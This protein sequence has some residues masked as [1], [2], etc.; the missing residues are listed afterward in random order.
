MDHSAH[1]N[2]LT[3]EQRR[4]GLIAIVVS[5]AIAGVILGLFNPLISL[6]L[7][8][9]DVSTT[10]N[11]V[12]AAMP[13]IAAIIV[14]PFLPRLTMALGLLQTI[15][16]GAALIMIVIPLF[17]VFTD[18]WV[19][20]GLRFVMGVGG[21]MHW[22]TTEIWI[23]AAVKDAYR[24]RVLGANT[25][26][27]SAGMACGPLALGIIGT[28]GTLPFFISTGIVVLGALPLLF[29]IGTAPPLHEPQKGA[30]LDACRRAP[31]PMVASLIEGFLFVAIMVLLPLY[32]LRSGFA[33]SAA[34]TMLSLIV[35]G[36]IV[37]SLPIG[38]LADHMDRRLLLIVNGVVSL[39]CC[40]LLPAVLANTALL[41]ITLFLLG[42][43]TA[44]MYTLGLV[45]LGEIFAPH[46]LGSAT[47]VFILVTQIGGVAGP[48]I[49]GAGMDA[50]NP[51]GFI[52]VTALANGLFCVFAVWRY[53]AMRRR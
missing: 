49:G 15:L 20:Y 42:S 22:V 4:R 34:I 30:L 36:Q 13:A 18:V 8:R 44:G 10:W 1:R 17:T 21:M 53:M 45:R 50:W 51:H 38:W 29:A 11:G 40:L 31:T 5:T 46:E 37:A 52:V 7:E 26:L 25:A 27:F 35:V 32:A 16:V 6:K 41:F 2:G 48:I 39:L 19:W 33:E 23:N 12:N 9:M 14:A 28:E 47:A 24:G 43:A 3:P